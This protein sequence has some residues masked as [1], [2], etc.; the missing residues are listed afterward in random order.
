MKQFLLDI[1]TPERKAFSEQVNSVSVPTMSG[2]IEV[3]A[4]HMPLFTSLTEGE[5]RVASGDKQ[6]FLAIGGGIME[7]QDDGSVMV[8]VSRAVHAAEI[9]EAEI[10]KAMEN[11]KTLVARKAQGV[12]L[13]AALALLRRSSLELKVA[14]RRGNPIRL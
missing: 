14:R 5:V 7:V 11:A 10:A 4:R 1:V 9:N 13:H 8:L 2:Q 6:Y 3:L 12:E